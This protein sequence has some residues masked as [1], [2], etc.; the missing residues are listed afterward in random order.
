MYWPRIGTYRWA[1]WGRTCR[2]W[3]RR[4]SHWA[5]LDRPWLWA[6]SNGEWAPGRW[7]RICT[8]MET[9]V[10]NRPQ[11]MAPPPP[12]LGSKT[13]CMGRHRLPVDGWRAFPLADH[14]NH[15]RGTDHCSPSCLNDSALM[16]RTKRSN[17]KIFDKTIFQSHQRLK[18][19]FH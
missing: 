13:A 2:D 5:E 15:G 3:R 19:S 18:K 9:R 10:G 4:T 11:M 8:R 16:W 1:F 14:R 7:G 12:I 6:S 17:R